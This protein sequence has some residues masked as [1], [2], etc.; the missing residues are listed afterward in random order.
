M[1]YICQSEYQRLHNTLKTY[2]QALISEGKE[3]MGKVYTRRTE[4]TQR[5]WIMG[6]S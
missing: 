2:C 5:E 1:N 6:I 3:K 4:S